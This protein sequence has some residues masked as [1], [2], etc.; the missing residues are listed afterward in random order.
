MDDQRRAFDFITD[1]VQSSLHGDCP[2][3][4][5]LQIQGEGGTGKSKVIQAVTAMF[6]AQGVRLW[7]LKTA[8]TGIAA[9]L[10]GGET[11]HRLTGLNFN[12]KALG[13]GTHTRLE[14]IWKD[15]RYLIVDEVSMVSKTTLVQ[16]SN[17]IALAKVKFL[18]A[19]KN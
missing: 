17:N 15:V 9:S 1:H 12:G 14:S 2:N 5:L 13:S 6:E 10:I 19:I 18:C 4:L 11:I 16:M 3:Q 7:L 8:Y